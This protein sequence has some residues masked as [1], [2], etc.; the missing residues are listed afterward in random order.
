MHEQEAAIRGSEQRVL[1]KSLE[2]KSLEAQVADLEKDLASARAGHVEAEAFTMLTMPPGPDISPYHENDDRLRCGH[3]AQ[4]LRLLNGAIM[5]WRCCTR[6][7]VR[8]RCEPMSARQRAALSVPR[9]LAL[10]DRDKPLRL[11]PST[12]R[13]TI[14]R[15]SR[16]EEA[17]QRN[18]LIL[19]QHDM[20]ALSK[21]I[22]K[23]KE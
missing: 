18:L 2:A 7:G 11:K 9:L 15:R 12:M 22:D 13:G 19:K 21:A 17:L 14:E 3:R 8:Y 20:T 5:C 4:V 10:L 6:R 1:E 16:H 23:A